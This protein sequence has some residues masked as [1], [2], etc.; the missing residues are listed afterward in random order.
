MISTMLCV[1]LLPF[2]LIA[3]IASFFII[4]PILTV[5]WFIM[6]H[7]WTEFKMM[8]MEDDDAGE[9]KGG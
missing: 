3:T 2:A 1:I 5:A 8:C 7:G 4:A 9:S 6:T